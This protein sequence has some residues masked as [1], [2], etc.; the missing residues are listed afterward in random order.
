MDISFSGIEQEFAQNENEY[1]EIFKRVMRSGRMFQ[2]PETERFEDEIAEYVG[3]KYAVTVG[4]CTD[5]LYF[6]LRAIGYG[7]KQRVIV[8]D[9]SFVASASCI[10]RA[11]ARPHFVDV[12]SLGQIDWVE[13]G[14]LTQG[15]GVE[16]T[17]LLHVHLYGWMSADSV[18]GFGGR[19]C[20]SIEDAAQALGARCRGRMAGSLGDISCISFDPMK[21]LSSPTGGGVV[22][23]D[24]VFL[25][26]R[27]TNYRYHGRPS[28]FEDWG[29]NSQMAE[30]AAALL[31]FKLT[32]L[33]A[34]TEQRRRIAH[35]Y[36]ERLNDC[37]D[38]ILPDFP[39][40]CMS[41]VW[42]K[43]SIR[44][45]DRDG[46]RDYLARVGIPTKVHYPYVLHWLPMFRMHRLG[47][48]D[49]HFG[50]AIQLANTSLSLPI[51]PFLTS[52]DLDYI[53]EHVLAFY[54]GD[55]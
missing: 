44:A 30:L 20:F 48:P 16:N 3:R 43:F 6:V 15:A 18:I 35:G 50:N 9:L 36:S 41:H 54:E 34:C 39:S 27:V 42:H 45:H 37:T 19:Q 28:H 24:D 22:L 7:P 10:A 17:A 33:G 40:D 11:R 13:V 23:T 26:G 25:A 38:I 4:S 1:T 49:S 2:G 31:S 8:P 46:L 51:H 14:R 5:A 53:A 47:N 52:T 12:T 55:E 21:N 29:G 32:G